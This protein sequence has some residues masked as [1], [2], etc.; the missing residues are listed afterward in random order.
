[1]NDQRHMDD[2]DD[3]GEGDLERLLRS[4]GPRMEPP[5]EVAA[6]VRAA[7]AEEWRTTVEA[8]RVQA[9]AQAQARARSQRWLAVAASVAAVGVTVWLAAPRFLTPATV[10]T[11]ARVEG[12]VE[13][14]RGEA[15]AWAPLVANATLQAGDTLRTGTDG[16]VALH[17]AD[18]LD[19]RVDTTT[20]LALV[21]PDEAGLHAGRVYVDAGAAGGQ[22]DAFTVATT[23]GDIHHLGTQY[24]VTFRSD[25]LD[26]AVREG[27]VAI[28]GGHAPLVANAGEWV[29][30]AADGQ[31]RRGRVAPQSEAWRWAQSIAPGFV[32]EGRSLDEFL[33]WAARETGHQLVYA[34]AAAAR[35]AET[36][37]LKGSVTGLDPEAAVAAVL[38]TTPTLRHRYAGAQLRIEPAAD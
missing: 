11:V 7:V 2:G 12:G 14:R 32:I 35:T 9:Q 37:E 17:R 18:G 28:D 1:M 23:G 34:S 33:T 27:T 36:L 20:T 16:R 25:T 26:V 29:Q 3:A 19:V 6:A 31:V 21:A 38:T 10:A 22:A 13:V 30:L 8:R 24:G 5:P 4:A 15:G